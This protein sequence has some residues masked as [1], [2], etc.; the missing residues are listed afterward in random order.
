MRSAV[1]LFALLAYAASLRAP[2]RQPGRGVKG[3]QD[4]PAYWFN[5][6]IDHLN[7]VYNSATFQ[8]KYYINDQ[9]F[10]LPSSGPIV[11]VLYING[12]GPIYG[13]PSSSDDFTV[14]IAQNLSALLV[15]LEH[16]YYGESRPFATLETPNLQFLSSK[17]ALFDLAR[18][19]ESYR[20]GVEAKFQRPSTVFTVGGSYSGALSAWFR[21]KYPHITVGSLASSGVV[22]AILDF[23]QF[24]EQVSLS[25]GPNCTQVLQ[26]TTA[27]LEQA[28]LYGGDDSEAATKRLFQAQSVVD[29]GDFFYMMGDIMATSVQY[30]FQADLCTPLLAVYNAGDESQL[31]ATF[32][33]YTVSF[34]YPIFGGAIHYSTEFQQRIHVPQEDADRQWWFQTCVEFGYFQTAPPTNSIRSQTVNIS[35]FQ[36]HCQQVFQMDLWPDTVA[37]NEYYG[38]NKT[39]GTRIFF[40]NGSQD[41]WQRASARGGVPPNEPGVIIDCN[42]CGHCVDLGGCPGGCNPAAPLDDARTTILKWINLWVSTPEEVV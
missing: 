39:A 2:L 6:T 9:Y 12:E 23:P 24:D 40:S 38:S 31:L 33:N 21:V 35:Y 1:I 8:Q 27:Q 3:Q 18:F 26:L 22:N 4:F 20:A 37:T 19:V 34:W 36:T 5:Q 42:N 16:R 41:P 32:A 29:N 14:M 7:P 17:Q 10:Q 28:V 11:I 25:V 15:T 13:P 30:G